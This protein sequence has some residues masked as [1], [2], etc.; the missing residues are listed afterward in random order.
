MDAMDATIPRRS[1]VD[2]MRG[3]AMFDVATYEEVEAD[4][5][6]T[7]QAAVVVVLAAIAA[8]IGNAFRG[9]PGILGG[10]VSSLIGWAVWSG[11]TYIVGTRVFKGTATWGELLRTLGFAQAPGVLMVAA[12]VPVLGVLVKIVIWLWMLGTGI[13][14][15]RQALDFDTGKAVMTALVGWLASIVV[16]WVLAG[17]F[18]A[19]LF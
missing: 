14:A 11:I 1:I 17:I 12:I 5:S 18:G 15:I 13:V 19:A 2:R 16:F 10:L 8:A 3:A 7:G 6:A 4:T 9:G